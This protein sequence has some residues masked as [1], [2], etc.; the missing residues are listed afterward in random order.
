MRLEVRPSGFFS[1]RDLTFSDG[2]HDVESFFIRHTPVDQLRHDRVTASDNGIQRT[3]SVTDKILCVTVPYVCT[4]GKTHQLD[5]IVEPGRLRLFDHLSGHLGT[6][7][8]KSECRGFR[9]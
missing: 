6:K 5:K 4:M 2:L 1:L 8:R 3:C 7:L 9:R